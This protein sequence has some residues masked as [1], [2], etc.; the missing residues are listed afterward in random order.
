MI[1]NIMD[2]I[3]F[4]LRLPYSIFCICLE[5]ILYFVLF[6]LIVLRSILW[7]ISPIIGQ[8]NWSVPKWYPRAKDIYQSS[9]K[10]LN[11]YS[12]II[13]GVVILGIITYFSGNYAYHWYL[14]KPK[15][16][17]PATV[18][19]N[20][21]G[22]SFYTPKESGTLTNPNQSYLKIKFT[23]HR[24]SPAPIDKIGKEITEGIQISPEIKGTWSWHDDVNIYFKPEQPWPMGET[25]TVKLDD[26]KLL[27]SNN[28]INKKEN[29]F[30][31]KTTDFSFEIIN[32]ELYQNP[33][34]PDDKQGIYEV[35]FSHPVDP[36]TFE[37]NLKLSLFE[38][39]NG[40]YEP[41]KFV[42]NVN[43]TIN[44]NKDKTSAYIK[45]DKL[46]LADMNRYLLLKIAKGV[47]S[48]MG[49]SPTTS[50]SSK[51]IDIPNKYN[52]SI[53]SSD[54]SFVELSNNEIRQIITINLA[55]NVK[56]S[57]LQ[58]ALS[59]W[60]LPDPNAKYSEE[61]YDKTDNTYKTKYFI[62]KTVLDKSKRLTT[63]YIE[64]DDNR[65][66]QNQFSFEINGD[67]RQQIFITVDPSLTS[68]GGY[69]LKNRYEKLM[70]INEFDKL[71]NFAATGS[72]LSLSGDK[73]I[74]VV[75]R[76]VSQIK[77][78]LKRVIPSQLQHLVYDNES[79]FKSM[80][81]DGYKSDNFVE[82]YSIIKDVKGK[83]GA[84]HY[85]DFDL[86]PYLNKDVKKN[87]ANR[88][89]FLLNLYAQ[90]DDAIEGE[91]PYDYIT[92]RFILVTDLGII[93]K[94]SLDGSY[95]LFVQSINSG[96]P[97]AGAKVSILG[98]NGIEI[99]SSITDNTGHVHFPALS[100][101][102]KGIKPLLFLIEKG[103]DMSFLP[104]SKGYRYYDRKL[105][106]SRFDV[107]GQY[108]TIDR[109]E[110]HAHLFSDR[111]IY[112]PGD[113]FHIGM[114]IKA[115]DWTKSLNGV[116][117]VAT[118]FDAK[119][120]HVTTKKIK[121]DDYGFNEIS[122]KTEE[123]SPTGQWHVY[124]YIDDKKNLN[125]SDNDEPN[126]L[127]STSVTV[128]EF[129]PDKT[130][131]TAQIVTE[132]R[133]GWINQSDIIAKVAAKNLFGTPAQDRRV[134]SKL[135]LQPT[136][137]SFKKYEDY[138]FYRV[139]N[140]RSNFKIE[141]EDNFTNEEG[142]ADI[143][144]HIE[145]FE[146]QYV[147]KFLTDVF[148]PNSGRS[149][150]ATDSILISASDYLVGSKSDGH[151]SYIKRDSKRLLNL[152]AIN[153]A[154]D[155]ITLDNLKLVTLEKK[156]L[157]IL[158]EQSSGVYKYESKQKDV[159]ISQIP[160]EIDNKGTV[161]QIPTNTPG[162]YILQLLNNQNEVIYQTEYTIA[163]S[164]NVTR[165]LDR[166]S[167]LMLK[168]DA[169]EYKPGQDIEIAITAPY[170][171]SGI[172]TIERDK[173]YAWKWF[174][175][176]TTSS[177]QKITLPEE[178]EGNAYINVQFIR[179]PNSEEI[180]MS[181]LS[182]G[183]VP[184]KV[185][186]DKF[187]EKVTLETPELIKPGE[188][189]PITIKTASQQRV[190]VF[191][192]DEGI[193]QVAGYQLKNPIKNFIRK[194][195]LS[196]RTDQIL[197][198]ILPEYK[199]LLTL[200][201]PG[202]DQD[203]DDKLNAHLNPFKRKTDQPVTYWSGI[204]DVNGEKQLNYKVPE[205][206]SGK[207]RVM[208][209]TVG[210]KTMGVTQ[211]STTVRN[212]FVLSP[213]VPYFVTPND[214]FEISLLVANNI[215]EIGNEEIPI[216][217][218]L[219]TTPHL[220][221][222]DESI[223]TVKLASM[224]EGTLSFRLKA[225]EQ[226]GSG[227][228]LFTATYKDKTI[229]RQVSTS[230]RPINP[231]RIKT[232]MGRMDGKTQT[233]SGFRQMYPEFNEQNAGVSYSPMILAKGL[234]EYLDDYEYFC[235][236]QIVSRALPLVIGNKYPEFNLITDKTIPFTAVMQKLQS[237]Q[238]SEGAIGLWYSTYNVDPFI[239]LYT[240]H[241]LLEA[242]DAGLVIPKDLLEN[243]NK[244]VKLVASGSLTDSYNLRLRAYAIYL[245]TRQNIIT[246]NQIASV[247]EDLNHNYQSWSTDLTALYLASSYKML[248]M[249]KH[250]DN[251]LKPI[252]K[253]LSKAYDNAWWNHNYYDPLVIDA[254]KIYLISKHFDN[255]INDIPAQAIENMTL[256][257][258]EERYTTQSAAMTMLALDSY[259]SAIK[260]H[261]LD[262]ND[263]TVTTKFKDQQA[264]IATI[265]KLKNLLA[266]GK[267]N[268]S[269]ESIS[270]HNTKDLPA[271]YLISQKGFDR[272]IQQEPINKG[273]EIYREFTDNDG[274]QIDKVKLGETINVT[275]RVRSISKEGLTNIAIVDMLPSGFEVV[276]Q[277]AINNHAESENNEQSDASEN[278]NS[279][280]Q[281]ISP[282]ATGKYTWYPDYTD[283]REDRV[284]IY[285]STR[286]DHIQTFNYQIKATN[287]GQY[288]VPPAYGEAM[289]DRDIQAVSK[290]GNK[291]I[292]EPR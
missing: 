281:W 9:I 191:A 245:L 61:Y 161:Y 42:Q 292:I 83:S 239:T 253:D 5:A 85:S 277:K 2:I 132:N 224:K 55:Y 18:I 179:D 199:R 209:V 146:G 289:Y 197:D 12:L 290:G 117:L 215:T 107:D 206:F 288:A 43:F 233:F 171:G 111:G 119:N 98:A 36:T 80:S 63:R 112:R 113:T 47:T 262:E 7:L 23:G 155:Q 194:K 79:D 60:Q 27:D 96:L 173:V 207:I 165:S 1:R 110:L 142:I 6:L 144:L 100:D 162:N 254:G 247:I 91:D 15:P 195:V 25:Y 150:A 260:A 182:Y 210:K 230:V 198:L 167:E 265:A 28:L 276:Q 59:I 120:S 274:K 53:T 235:S 138:Q 246:T 266:K 143:D 74:P 127:G 77:L 187:R 70:Q 105:N 14:N 11:N 21:Y 118:I 285:G 214:E 78:E 251:L 87:E 149:V 244:Y 220:A 52:L 88:G 65:T 213:N 223:K 34:V 54:I 69:T 201:A 160:F 188:T 227:D 236:E 58:K 31:F 17:E 57:D 228:L 4:I 238:N 217:V 208:A 232:I 284:I 189:I 109:G 174:K 49:G 95:D 255:K 273:L 166:N 181:P 278:D 211:T 222:L 180:F 39:A 104:I 268:D 283:V 89:V 97:V 154:L 237:R 212:D 72:L 263:L 159:I 282:I 115:D 192:V 203:S 287:I 56:A 145:D 175:T 108:E 286:N 176:D 50:E 156:Y 269:V 231:Y 29:I 153:P 19:V 157:S 204:I 82:K 184:F 35:K 261:E 202:G 219:T 258:N 137:F 92:S 38:I 141:L 271:W 256:M 252:W 134:E 170:I 99:T 158:V 190:A 248:K 13:G 240:V 129:E 131:V 114:I 225:T 185:S 267:F 135:Y 242:K 125:D 178:V 37:Q 16:I 164:A 130:K 106:Y 62:D 291:I 101:Y 20:T 264:K 169:N 84:I 241:F 234:T 26:S 205:F 33:I 151:L 71:L 243:A 44:Y 279:E 24:R 103:K 193:L 140:N 139:G 124:L 81:F 121:V 32:N 196:V 86:A 3:R 177:V 272:S 186:D 123:S 75:S 163:G 102:Y 30:T 229:T 90:N 64:T 257:L 250:A 68:D 40:R 8:I 126:F 116:N 226:L 73:K 200:S 259:N 66:Y 128:R 10:R 280:E 94:K 122:F 76:N 168:I 41:N 270:F 48:S 46:E 152:I 221:V 51:D 148:E 275:V 45:S 147:A 133:Q 218:K 249:D 172:I 67:Q 136:R 216:K 93:N 22:I 183:V